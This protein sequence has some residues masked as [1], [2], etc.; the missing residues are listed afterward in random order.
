[1]SVFQFILVFNWLIEGKFLNKAKI[2]R[3]N[4]EIL[5][6]GDFNINYNAK[7]SLNSRLLTQIEGEL[8]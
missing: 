6:I 3:K 7:H 1:M 5:V 8:Y 2:L 4:Y